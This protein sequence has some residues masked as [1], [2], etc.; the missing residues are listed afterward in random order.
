MIKILINNNLEEERSKTRF[1]DAASR[2]I[3]NFI[4]DQLANFPDTYFKKSDIHEFKI[5]DLPSIKNN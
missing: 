3:K 2:D 1:L 4:V 5:T